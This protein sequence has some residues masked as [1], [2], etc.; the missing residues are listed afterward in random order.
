MYRMSIMCF[1]FKDIPGID[2]SKCIKMALVH[3][4]AEAIVGDITPYC[5]ISSS[6]KQEREKVLF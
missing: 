1:L 4:L 6:E 3:D 2:Y 5:G